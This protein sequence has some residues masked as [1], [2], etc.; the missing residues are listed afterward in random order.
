[1]RGVW[2]TLVAQRA[3]DSR[4]HE[5]DRHVVL[6]ALVREMPAVT[7]ATSVDTKATTVTSAHTYTCKT[8][9]ERTVHVRT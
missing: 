1:M 9:G 3:V 6:C 7:Q 8:A 2:S 5:R 4:R